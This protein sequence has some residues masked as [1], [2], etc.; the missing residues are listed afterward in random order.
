MS[1]LSVKENVVV[2]SE[3]AMLIPEVQVVY[4]NDKQKDKSYF[5]DVITAIYYIFKP[6]GPYWNK[7]LSERIEIVN[8][9]FLRTKWD[10]LSKKD[11]VIE[12]RDCYIDLCQTM[13]EKLEE[14]LKSDIS[15]LLKALNSVPSTVKRTIEQHAEVLCDDNVFHK[16]IVSVE[17]S[18]P[19]FEG[20]QKLWDYSMTFS[21]TFKQIQE[22][23]KVEAEEKEAQDMARRMFDKPGK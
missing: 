16:V 10:T 8:E 18:I 15:E 13:A 7:P 11:G 22:M 14:S 5:Q 6:N 19:N 3:D 9:D 12:L 2:C 4:N 20:K 23:L 17:V 21:K 1:F